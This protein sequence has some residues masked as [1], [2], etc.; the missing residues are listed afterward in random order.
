MEAK[1]I[2]G[3]TML[4]MEKAKDVSG[5]LAILFKTDYENSIAAF[6]GME[7]RTDLMDF[8]LSKNFAERL[9][10]LVEITPKDQRD[11]VRSVTARW[12]LYNVKLMLRPGR[13]ISDTRT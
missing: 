8:A 10:K 2:S 3:A 9:G 7:I 5:M 4:E 13:G 12:D 11:L 1:L 6:G